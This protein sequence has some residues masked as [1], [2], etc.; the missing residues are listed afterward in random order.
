[1]NGSVRLQIGSCVAFDGGL[2]Q[3]VEMDGPAVVL[4]DRRAATRRV[5]IGHLLAAGAVG[6]DADRDGTDPEPAGPALAALS[7]AQRSEVTRR[8]EHAAEVVTGYRRGAE[9]LAG[10]GEPRPAYAPGTTMKSRYGAK[11]AELGMSAA[12]VRRW[13]EAFAQHGPAGLID[14]RWLRGADALA[15]VDPRWLAMLETV[16]A[17]H[18]SASTPT[19]QL[20]LARVAARLDA[21]HGVGAVRMPGRTKALA[22][23]REVSRGTSAF[24]GAKAKRSIAG[25]PPT[26]YGSLRATRPGEFLLLDTTPLDVF[27][28]DQMTLRWVQVQASVAIDLYDRCVCALRL[29]PVSAQAM[30]AAALLFEALRPLGPP[31]DGWIDVRPPYHGLPR[32]VVLDAD[33]LVDARGDPVLPSVAAETVVMDHGRIYLSE[34]VMSVCA[35]LG[36]SVQPAR[37]YQGSDKAVIERFFRTLREQ[38]LVALPGYKG[39]NVYHRAADAE[40]EAFFFV[41]ELEQIIRSWLAVYH[42]SPHQGLCI[43]QVPGLELCPLEMF[44]HGVAR[45]GFLQVAAR[46]DL[47]FDFLAVR[48][49]TIQHYG[50]HIDGLRYDGPGLN[51]YRNRTSGFGGRYPGKWPIRIDPQDVSRAF[52]RDPESGIWH[53]LA[54]EHAGAVRGPFSGEAMAYARA[55]ATAAGRH[56][57]ANRLLADLLAGWGAG[58]ADGRTERRMALRASQRSLVLV[59]DVSE[60]IETGTLVAPPAAESD[61]DEAG[62]DDSDAELVASFP[63]GLGGGGRR[64]AADFYADALEVL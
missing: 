32:Q 4:R 1:M 14:Q 21:E 59:G 10:P 42:R 24:G 36:V 37:L 62:D 28:M 40:G 38:L 23:L 19:K 18:V 54:W 13:A 12:T 52:F 3:V 33:K 41:A 7:E 31:A 30:D 8:A 11:A 6:V 55:L 47:V 64:E 53:V 61:S 22:V 5:D 25:R 45:A 51:P 34:H 9:A 49:R 16:L 20:V 60:Q 57:D 58:L 39:P 27:A 26:P 35:R 46:P 15:G 48:W 29:T 43:A 44:A 2:L 63:A 17:E 56:V 50:V